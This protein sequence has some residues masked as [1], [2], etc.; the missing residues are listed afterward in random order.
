M[1]NITEY[2]LSWN[3]NSEFS[4][5][6]TVFHFDPEF[7]RPGFLIPV[8]KDSDGFVLEFLG[9]TLHTT[10]KLMK[11]HFTKPNKELIK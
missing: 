5:N 3:N 1:L 11:Y 6:P 7:V 4:L 10:D 8:Y 9:K 2:L